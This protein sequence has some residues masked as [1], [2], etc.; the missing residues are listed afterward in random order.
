MKITRE[1]TLS[2]DKHGINLRVY[3]VKSTGNAELG[4]VHIECPKGHFEEFYHQVS[5]FT[6]YILE[7]EGTFFLDGQPT[8]VK[9]TDLVVIPPNTKIYYLGKMKM[10]LMTTPAY[11]PEGEVHV[12]GIML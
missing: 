6:Y 9:A 8:P 4:V 11:T 12:R 5:I 10:L 1:Q 2:L 7:G 3:P